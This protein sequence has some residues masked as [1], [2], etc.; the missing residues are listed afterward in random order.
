MK[1]KKYF[2]THPIN[3][4]DFAQ[5]AGISLRSLFNALEEKTD[6]SISIAMAIQDLSEGKVQ[7]QDLV[8]DKFRRA[9]R[10]KK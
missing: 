9:R 6:I 3:K 8:S 2:E 5:M 1:L 10:E 7:C 4:S